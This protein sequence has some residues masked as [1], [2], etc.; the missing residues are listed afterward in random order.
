MTIPFFGSH[1]TSNQS[2]QM[3]RQKR[4][5]NKKKNLMQEQ[6]ACDLEFCKFVLEL[7]T[8]ESKVP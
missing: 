2:W 6:I 5:R 7:E 4:K 3:T 1:V 8:R